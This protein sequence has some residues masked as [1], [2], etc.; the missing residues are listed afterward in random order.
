MK[1]WQLVSVLGEKNI[2]LIRGLASAHAQWQFVADWL[3]QYEVLVDTQDRAKLDYELPDPFVG[4]L[5]AKSALI[6]YLSTDGW[7]RSWQEY[8]DDKLITALDAFELFG[9]QAL[10]E[11]YEK[12]SF[13]VGRHDVI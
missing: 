13:E 6:Y 8:P 5:L 11:A 10:E 3:A 4:L 9:E 12:G 2:Q 1:L 7:L